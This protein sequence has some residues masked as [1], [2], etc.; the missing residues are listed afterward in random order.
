MP[1][2]TSVRKAPVTLTLILGGFSLALSLAG[3][4]WL[5]QSIAH[6][7]KTP[8]M[9]G[10]YAFSR[11]VTNAGYSI[12]YFV[13]AAIGFVASRYLYTKIHYLKS[14][15]HINKA[16]GEWSLFVFK[17]LI[18]IGIAG[19]IVKILVGRQRP[20]TTV[21]FQN[22]NFS[23]FSLDSHFH[24]FPSGHTQVM[25]TMATI[26][27][28]I[29]PKWR[30]L[31]FSVGIFLGFTRVVIHQHFFSDFTGGA[32]LGIAGTLWIYYYWPPKLEK[33]L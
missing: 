13:A 19:Q 28:L 26:A 29:W 10:F 7:F 11:E 27:T 5:D 33:P 22:L 20:H 4:F 1:S 16:L 32:F 14:N 6:F 25:L 30:Y 23:P 3:F 8:Q 31:W 2:V 18:L 17:C 15:P 21:D 24:S 12:H 9:E